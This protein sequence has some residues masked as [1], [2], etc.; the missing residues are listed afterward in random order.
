MINLFKRLKGGI[1]PPD[2]KQM[3]AEHPIKL[4]PF[5]DRLILPLSQHI[6]TPAHPIVKV[7]EKVLGGQLLAE[8]DGH[9]S[10][11]VHSPT[12]GKVIGFEDRRVPHPSNLTAPCLVLEVDGDHKALEQEGFEDFEKVP[13][14]E[15]LAKIR[16]CGIAGM[17]GAGFPTDA[18]LKPRDGQAIETLIINGM[19]CE[20]YITADDRL[21]RELPNDQ[22]MGARILAHL[23]DNP[24]RCVIAVEDNKPEAIAALR[25]AAAGTCVEIM[26][27]PTKYPS[28]SEKQLIQLVTGKKLPTGRLPSDIGVM[29]QN[30]TT[31]GGVFRAIIQGKPM[32]ARVTTVTGGAIAKPGNYKVLMGTPVSHVLKETGY[33]KEISSR[34]IM[35]GPMMGFTITDTEI[36]IIKTSNCVL[37]P[38][39][40]EFGEPATPQACI[41]CGR[42]AQV[43]PM[44]L[45][46]QQ[47]YWYS[48]SRD[49]DKLQR[50][51][52]FDCIECGSCAYVCTS[53]IPLVHYFRAAKGEIR[54][55]QQ[56][57]QAA[58]GAKMRH[59]KRM[60]RMEALK[61]ERDAKR[62]SRSKNA[63]AAKAKA[64]PIES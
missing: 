49:A 36:P 9:F 19:E 29:V 13:R 62:K 15:L 33:Q 4:M 28:G 52:L 43:C 18:K 41:R 38:T 58:A 48:Q 17:G 6:G 20:P 23:L 37:A 3:S 55:R 63:S 42:C 8:A 50:Y 44:Q 59:E 25:E 1:H 46:P 54:A 22:V 21:M 10:L 47:L 26:E 39:E 35:G 14:A 12:S 53:N 5:A 64:E 27:L 30:I 34:V 2:Q 40:Q 32:G 51:N 60:A 7:G 16:A 57:Q 56:Q 24:A 31:T 45:L 61:A 11:P